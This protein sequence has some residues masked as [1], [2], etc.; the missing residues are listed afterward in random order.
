M[1]NEQNKPVRNAIA[2]CIGDIGASLLSSE[3]IPKVL[4]ISNDNLWPNPGWRFKKNS[5]KKIF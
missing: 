4:N 5:E 3:D 1:A 2:D